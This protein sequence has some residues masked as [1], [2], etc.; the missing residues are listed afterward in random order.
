LEGLISLEITLP[1]SGHHKKSCFNRF[2]VGERVSMPK[3]NDNSIMNK[4]TKRDDETV[5]QFEPM[6]SKAEIA[7]MLSVSPRTVENWKAD[8]VLPFY[9]LGRNVRYRRSEVMKAME[10]FHSS[11]LVA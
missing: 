10:K 7:E 5:I 3:I 11:N 1:G 9:K 6:V 4:E 8:G 2:E